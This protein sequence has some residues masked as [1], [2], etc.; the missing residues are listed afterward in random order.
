MVIDSSEAF[1]RAF[2]TFET[3]AGSFDVQKP[4]GVTFGGRPLRLC[5][6]KITKTASRNNA[7]RSELTFESRNVLSRH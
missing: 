6:K 5:Q 7:N 4:F 1:A 3:G 2:V